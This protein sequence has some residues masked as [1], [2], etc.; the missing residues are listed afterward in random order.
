M[1][2]DWIIDFRTICKKENSVL[3]CQSNLISSICSIIQ[4]LTAKPFRA[5]D[6][7]SEDKK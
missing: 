5:P 2:H 3:L 7:S 1:L 6:L 4:S